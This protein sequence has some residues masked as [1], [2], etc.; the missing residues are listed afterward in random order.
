MPWTMAA[1]LTWF[2]YI[3][4]RGEF[5]NIEHD[6]LLDPLIMQSFDDLQVIRDLTGEPDSEEEELSFMFAAD[7]YHKENISGDAGPQILM[8]KKILVDNYVVGY[9]EEIELTF[10]DYLRLNY[11]WACFPA[12]AWLDEADREPFQPILREVAKNLNPF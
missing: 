12:L 5:T 11:Q 3:D 7:A 4:F 8:S 9:T 6:L 10:M 2:K 1:F